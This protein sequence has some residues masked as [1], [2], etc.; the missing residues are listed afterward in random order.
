ML[1]VNNSPN[2]PNHNGRFLNVRPEI[3]LL[4][5]TARTFIQEGITTEYATQI[6]GTT[7]D[8]GRL[9][10]QL[11]TKSSRVLYSSDVVPLSH[12]PASQQPQ[13][14]NHFQQNYQQQQFLNDILSDTDD[15]QRNN[16]QK[17]FIGNTD[18][19]DN[20]FLVF[21]TK[22]VVPAEEAA[23]FT[24]KQSG[25]SHSVLIPQIP[26]V[27]EEPAV[28]VSTS[29]SSSSSSSSSNNNDEKLPRPAKVIQPTFDLPTFTVKNEF[30]ANSQ[31]EEE[32]TTTENYPP[33]SITTSSS[34]SAASV[35]KQRAGKMLSLAHVTYYGFADFTTVVGDTVI[36][37]SP[38]TAAP[39]LGPASHITS[40]KGE[41]TLKAT[42]NI[43]PTKVTNAVHR[44]QPT[45][46]PFIPFEPVTP[47]VDTVD[48]EEA[49]N[50]ELEHN[51]VPELDEMEEYQQTTTVVED[52]SATTTTN[53]PIKMQRLP[54]LADIEEVLR[55][56]SADT[57]IPLKASSSSSSVVH[58]TVTP[59]MIQASETSAVPPTPLLSKPSNEDIAKILASLAAA[60]AVQSPSSIEVTT[61]TT[62]EQQVLGGI[63][64]IFFENDD[65]PFKL[66][67]TTMP[68]PA[69]TQTQTADPTENARM[70]DKHE[71]EIEE[72]KM[73]DETEV[74]QREST[75][76]QTLTQ[77]EEK[78]I[79]DTMTVTTTEDNKEENKEDCP[80]TT[81]RR[82]LTYLTTNYVAVNAELT[83]TTVESRTFVATS[84]RYICP[85][86]VM[87][88]IVPSASITKDVDE[89]TT[90][91]T[92]ESVEV[93]YTTLS[94]PEENEAE[95][96]ADET[97]EET[98]NTTTSPKDEVRE[99]VAEM[100][101]EMEMKMHKDEELDVVFKTLYTTYTYLTTF[102]HE[103]TSSVSSRKEV[104]T[105]I[106]TSTLDAA[107]LHSL[108]L[109][110][111]QAD[112]SNNIQP[113]THV[114]IGRPTTSFSHHESD[115]AGIDAILLDASASV[116]PTPALNDQQVERIL[117]TYY[118]TY[119]YFTTIFVDGETEVSSRTEVYTNY[120]PAASIQPTAVASLPTTSVKVLLKAESDN[121]I[122]AEQKEN[123]DDE[124][125]TSTIV[126][127]MI[128]NT[129]NGK[130]N[131]IV[132]DDQ[133]SSESNVEDVVRPTS[134]ILLL[135]T[136]YTTFTYF[137]TQYVGSASSNIL[138]R[139][140][141]VTNVVTETLQPTPTVSL[142]A[143]SGLNN[144]NINNND[145]SLPITYF[146]TYTYWTTLYK[147]GTVTT[148]SREETKSNIVRP[149]NVFAA[150]EES[151]INSKSIT[152]TSVVPLA[153]SPVYQPSQFHDE[154]GE[155]TTTEDS[156]P[157]TTAQQNEEEA[158]TEE[159]SAVTEPV[160]YYTTYTY[161]TT[162]YIGD[163]TV[164]SS[165]F[166]TD[167]NVV[168]EPTQLATGRAI[169]LVGNSLNALGDS[170]EKKKPI[171]Q[172]QPTG[173]VSINRGQIV[174]AE[175]ISTILYTTKAI[176]QYNGD[177]YAEIIEST[178][179]VKVDEVKKALL[180]TSTP[181][182]DSGR[183]TGLVRLIEGTIIAN[184]TTTLYQSKVIGTVIDGR[185]AQI[186]DSTS[187]FLIEKTAAA[188][189]AASPSSHYQ[190]SQ[191]TAVVNINPSPSSSHS[192]SPVLEGSIADGDQQEG[193]E[194]GEDEEGE[195]EDE[196]EEDDGTGRKKSRLTFS[197]RK[198]T[199]TPVIRPFAS[200]A[201]PTFNPKRKNIGASS[202]TIVSRSDFTPTI[203][204]TPALKSTSLDNR[205]FASSSIRSAASTGTSSRRF[206][207]PRSS[208]AIS[209]T[210]S[211]NVQ[212]Q[213]SS[214]RRGSSTANSGARIQ[215]TAKRSNL[216]RSSST[217]SR[218]YRIQPTST[219]RGSSSGAPQSSLY[220]TSPK[221]Q[222]SEED[223]D[224][225]TT[226]QLSDDSTDVTSADE[227][228]TENSRRNN[229]PLLRFR[230]P[231][232]GTRVSSPAAAPSA[233]S[234]VAPR[235]APS[236][237]I[238]QR[239]RSA[240]PTTTTTSTTPKPSK[241]R[242][243][244]RPAFAPAINR[245]RSANGLFPP[246]GLFR[247]PAT[248]I[249]QDLEKDETTEDEQNIDDL[250]N[251]FQ[252]NED[253]FEEPRDRRHHVDA[254]KRI[255]FGKRNKRQVDFGSRNPSPFNSRYR[256]PSSASNSNSRVTTEEPQRTDPPE[257]SLRTNRYQ[258][259]IRPTPASSSSAA[260]LRPQFTLREKDATSPVTT[261]RPNFRRPTT[262]T[263]SARRKPVSSTSASSSSASRPKAPRLRTYSNSGSSTNNRA[264]TTST[265][266]GRS[267]NNSRSRSSSASRQN[268]NQNNI[269]SDSLLQPSFD[270]SITVTH[271]I[272]TEI[273]IPVSN[274]HHTDFKTILTASPSTQVLAP[275][276]YSTSYAVNGI[277]N[278][279]FID[280][281]SVINNGATE[282]TQLIIHQTPTTRV[283][284]TPTT[285]RGRKTSFSHVIP[286]TVYRVEPIVSTINSP[287]PQI[288]ANAPLAN[289]LLSQLLLGNLNQQQQQQQL[290]GAPQVN[291]YY[292]VKAYRTLFY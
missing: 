60:N 191:A 75:T 161:Y 207:R 49:D 16:D 42:H 160:T 122:T 78:A 188:S 57:T 112:P 89:S 272:P 58:N 265:S 151:S 120:L 73:N 24:Y 213:S 86:S 103:S 234:P 209:P 220:S 132:L 79:E 236:A 145:A 233:S 137:T 268:L 181:A 135:Q 167:T 266:R 1:V 110:I 125:G 267:N 76:Q 59:D 219:L 70:F 116:T 278:L 203:T 270:G 282:V 216:F 13:V 26:A 262:S 77:S 241:P 113:T 224:Q 281:Q 247:N 85:T 17:T 32:D 226:L 251:E 290:L 4:T 111:N 80:V 186:I 240:T 43:Q 243:F 102:F 140:E 271:Y 154:N 208:G 8:N 21:P 285:I 190:T 7:L 223:Q 228:T 90:T 283:V 82:T 225:L 274:G 68:T 238:L 96:E 97:T 195:G 84:V 31:I 242:T 200:R 199:F 157:T 196:D 108:D 170:N 134:P 232:P 205:R 133:V 162:S 105:N 37:F 124:E 253:G 231:L 245:T 171:K 284:F 178:S 44:L 180:T 98:A 128:S 263:S 193:S 214:A 252:G 237:S 286:S 176:G 275:H 35:D 28:R 53:P 198:R 222:S 248:T 106:V 93:S 47:H 146:T 211:S 109:A 25:S 118:T 48:E 56:Q 149:T 61:T 41:A 168:V 172:L 45:R 136:S 138:S 23:V 126:T 256:R 147:E 141:T 144:N 164:V 287:T 291:Y 64:T 155:S 3:G 114:G 121:R 123:Q 83:T 246:R 27:H 239:G 163:E 229:N 156:L 11:L 50:D 38:Q 88:N 183:K 187:S 194:E 269:D 91:S 276:Q 143:S 62:S 153:I 65:D 92:T 127:T 185:Y 261:P 55:R 69:V 244:Q 39:A 165:R 95:K 158:T 192:N 63:T 210:S 36:V 130:N 99:A 288:A 15:W 227:P 20:A 259:R 197:T 177:L 54:T 129:S 87:S 189:I 264:R 215:P 204:A 159:Q 131:P 12:T 249:N 280:Q 148:T 169:N 173:L 260:G 277:S 22:R 230:R 107:Q 257:T 175:A 289:I 6:L 5:S 273:T 206:S 212:P 34:S 258:S 67:A 115:L 150:E 33:S 14:Q 255:T 202:A 182:I 221:P 81:L 71:N 179:T 117:K 119:T 279:V 94:G 100:E 72:E 235:R 292:F 74:E 19:L 142:L 217:N 166:E 46:V 201:R 104:V 40:I 18:Q 30:S 250:N 254:P 174:D 66:L 184:R 51:E 2:H 29:S 52:D 139:L 9:Y 10:A 101:M 152:F 218:N